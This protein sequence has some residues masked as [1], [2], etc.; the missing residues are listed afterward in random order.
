VTRLSDDFSRL[1]VQMQQETRR[2]E[3][4]LSPWDDSLTMLRDEVPPRNTSWPDGSILT[5]VDR[6]DLRVQAN[7]LKEDLR[8]M[9]N[10]LESLHVHRGD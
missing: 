9:H 10:C 2:L 7:A 3:H 4:L 5:D 6:E 1:R 8:A